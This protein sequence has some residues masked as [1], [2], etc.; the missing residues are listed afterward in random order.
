MA[1]PRIRTSDQSAF[2]RCRRKWNFTSPLREHLEPIE[3]IH[4]FWIGSGVHYSLED[5]H[6][7]RMFERPED[8][9]DLY[10][11]CFTKE[12]LPPNY[13]ELTELAHAMMAYYVDEWLPGREKLPIV[14][15]DG[16]PL[17]EIDF[18][19]DVDDPLTGKPLF[20]MCGQMDGI[21]KDSYG[22]WWIQ[23]YKAMKQFAGSKLD[24]D[25]Q[26]TSYTW[27]AQKLYKEPIAGLIYTEFRKEIVADPRVLKNGHVSA[28]KNQ[29][30]TH[31][32]FRKFL[33]SHYGE[34]PEE[35]I[36]VLNH[37]LELDTEDSDPYI[38]RSRAERTPEELANFETHL[39]AQAREMINPDIAIYP[40]PTN[41]CSWDCKFKGA[42]LAMNDG[43]D[44]KQI[45]DFEFHRKDRERDNWKNR[46]QEVLDAR[47]EKE[48][49]AQEE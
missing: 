46:I 11:D 42:C 2:R 18:E 21:V 25:F 47:A 43:S 44:Y 22:R 8:S 32:R 1:L 15:L 6:G 26:I 12:E 37:Y 13:E 49:I 14:K 30:T 28:A 20:T 29:K 34:V 9:F 40:N 33:K 27:C 23:E 45:L 36:D 4:Y 16:E 3:R 39:I 24:L 41:D 35:Y 7:V 5:Y 48:A 19:F 38:K 31:R 10:K 17:T